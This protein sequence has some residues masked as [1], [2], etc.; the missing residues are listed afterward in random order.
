VEE[1]RTGR[2]K[3][4]SEAKMGRRNKENRRTEVNE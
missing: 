2:S 1:M 4:Q 3:M